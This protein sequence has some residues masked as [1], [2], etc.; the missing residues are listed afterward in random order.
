M[1]SQIKN[2]VNLSIKRIVP[3]NI[4]MYFIDSKDYFEVKNQKAKVALTLSLL[5]FF[6]NQ[7]A[8]M[9]SSPVEFST[10]GVSVP[11][12]VSKNALVMGALV[13]PP[14]TPPSTKT[15]IA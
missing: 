6:S 5:E 14:A 15:V 12:H 8:D 11:S 2:R 7:S 1:K 9:N 3:K 13:I 4:N 10:I